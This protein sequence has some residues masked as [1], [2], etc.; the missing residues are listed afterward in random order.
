MAVHPIQ[1][2]AERKLSP[3]VWFQKDWCKSEAKDWLVS[4]VARILVVV[5]LALL[6]TSAPGFA[7][8]MSLMGSIVVAL[9][10]FVLPAAF[11]LK[12]MG[13]SLKLWR[14]AISYLI[15]LAGFAFALHGAYDAISGSSTGS[16]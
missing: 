1:E 7:R 11:H 10:A 8:L 16:S 15:L 2:I 14:R 5:V 13:S 9:L 3:S 12:L 4:Q 6:A